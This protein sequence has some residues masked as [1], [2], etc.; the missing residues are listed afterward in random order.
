MEGNM[1]YWDTHPMCGDR[2]MDIRDEL[3]GRFD[4]EENDMFYFEVD[5]IKELIQSN[6]D[7]L[8]GQAIEEENFT[9]P[10]IVVDNKIILNDEQIEKVFPLICDG[11]GYHRGY[12]QEIVSTLENNWNNF[13]CPQ[14]YCDQLRYYFKEIAKGILTCDVLN[15]S[16]GL[17]DT[18]VDT[19][20]EGRVGLVNTN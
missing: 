6:I 2:P 19:L 1:G 5:N 7:E 4:D 16:K 17:I 12:E 8:I 14:D 13:Q 15:Q 3:L 9:L 18:I 11:G 10:F 20:E